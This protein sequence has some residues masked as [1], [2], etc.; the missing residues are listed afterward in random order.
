MLLRWNSRARRKC[1]RHNLEIQKNNGLI[2]G[3]IRGVRDI[4]RLVK[5]VAGAVDRGLV[6]LNISQ[7]AGSHAAN[8]RTEMMMGAD[9]PA[10]LVGDLRRAQFVTP[11][12]LR[13]VT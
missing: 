4:A 2:G 1:G 7:L 9:I 12:Q 8:A 5:A 13:Q 10:R 11:V 6:R 3:V